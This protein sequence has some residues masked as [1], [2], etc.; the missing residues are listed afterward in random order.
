M[1]DF[2]PTPEQQTMIDAVNAIMT[3]DIYP[4]E[5][6]YHEN[7]DFPP[8]V[9]AALQA[10]VKEAGLWAPHMPKEAGGTGTGVVTLALMN[11]ILGRSPIAPRA[12]GTSAPDTSNQELLWLAGTPE[13]KAKYLMPAVSGHL[14]SAF[15]MTEPEFAGSDP[16]AL[17][18]RAE[19]QGVVWEIN[20]HKW[21]STGA[22][23]AAFVIV[24]AITDPDAA[25]HQRASMFI[26]D[27]DT[28]GMRVVR[29]VPV[30][31]DALGGHSEIVFDNCR[32]PADH[33]LGERGA[34]FRLAQMRLGP[35]RITHVMRWIGVMNRS[36]EMM[37]DRALRRR[38]R[39]RRLAD[40][41]TVQQ[42]IARSYADIQATRLLTL[43]AA[44]LMDRDQDSRLAVSLSKFSGAQALNRVVDRAL[45]LHG[46]LGFSKDT[47]LEAYY[48]E[49]RA[50]RIYDGVDEVHQIVVA[51]RLL[52]QFQ[53]ESGQ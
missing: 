11:E 34:G 22:S 41:G 21:F 28:P 8:H 13:Q 33:L 9:M 23:H 40:L 7:E 38:T 49:A 6:Y 15:A 10:T 51:K 46:A 42:E 16:V 27:R 4:A 20:G 31:G 43:Y 52:S 39:G 2:S 44:W 19:Q 24:M 3:R 36:F 5:T 53:A 18:T 45:Q 1:F 29:D 37:L 32:I 30:M 17:G 47:P 14:Y 35:G 12:F 26:V 48:R 25:P 50:A